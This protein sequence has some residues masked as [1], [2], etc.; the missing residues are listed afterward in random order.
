MTDT[1]LQQAIELMLS[2]AQRTGLDPAG[3]GPPRRYLWTD[4]F[5]VTNYLEIARRTGEQR[6]R[7]LALRL[8]DRVHHTLGRHRGD[9]REGWI[10]GLPDAEGEQ[11]PTIGG[12]RI[13]KPLPERGPGEP[14][15]PLLEWDRD[16]QYFHYLTKWMHALDQ[17]TRATHDLKFNCWAR[18]LAAVAYQAFVHSSGSGRDP[19]RLYWKMSIDLSRPLVASMGQ[20]DPLDG[21]VTFLQLLATPNDDCVSAPLNSAIAELESMIDPEGLG[22]DDPLGIGGL[23]ID[24]FRL[25][26]LNDRGD[27]FEAVLVAALAGLREYIHEPDLREAANRR[28]AFRELGL[29]IGLAAVQMLVVDAGPRLRPLVDELGKFA[30]FRDGFEKFWLQPENQRSETWQQHLDINEVMLAT[31]LA[32]RGF[33]LLGSLP[34]GVSVLNPL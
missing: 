11:R 12:L 33:L 21:V 1:R 3:D 27:L 29:A 22:T 25:A 6:Y 5:A 19:N 34:R 30:L 24:A 20:H 2:F 4:A 15:D 17:T 13:G 32:P 14:F 10:S 31:S 16:G 23:L 28:L 8:I 7:D 9:H 26:Q 18:D